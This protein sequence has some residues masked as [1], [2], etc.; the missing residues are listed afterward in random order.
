MIMI[1][2]KMFKI[3]IGFIVCKVVLYILYVNVYVY[4]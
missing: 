4:V 3:Y 2:I 1:I